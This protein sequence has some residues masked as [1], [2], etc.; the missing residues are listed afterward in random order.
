MGGCLFDNKPQKKPWPTTR[1]N[2]KDDESS[3]GRREANASLRLVVTPLSQ[4]MPPTAPV[5]L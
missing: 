2:M 5:A 3:E 1:G 4:K